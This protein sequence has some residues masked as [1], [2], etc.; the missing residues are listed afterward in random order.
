MARPAASP[1]ASIGALA[2]TNGKSSDR[3]EWP[4]Q[5]KIREYPEN[6]GDA[7]TPAGLRK[8]DPASSRRAAEGWPP[9]NGTRQPGAATPKCPTVSGVGRWVVHRTP[10]NT[11]GRRTPKATR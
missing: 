10:S 9:D 7:A 8:P 4:D 2:I 6:R 3:A 5:L 1:V 11:R